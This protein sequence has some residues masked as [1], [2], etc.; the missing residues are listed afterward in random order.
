MS[1]G[2]VREQPSYCRICEPTCGVI[3]KVVG[4]R[5]VDVRPDPDNPHSQGFMCAKARA[6]VELVYDPDRVLHPLKRVGG[7]GE[8]ERV[9][10]DEALDDIARRLRSIIDRHGPGSFATFIGNPVTGNASG[11]IGY[12]G[13]RA[14]T[15]S[16][17]NYGINGEDAASFIAACTLQFGSPVLMPKP[18][19]W[20]T[21]FLLMAGANPTVSH[22]STISEPLVNHAIQG[23]VDRGGRVVV[24]DPRQT[25]TA[26]KFEHVPIRPGT[27]AWLFAGML[28]TI[29]D[30]DLYD[31]AFVERHTNDFESLA[32]LLRRFDIDRCSAASRVPSETITDLARAFARSPTAVAYGRTGTCTQRFGTLN[33][34]LI[35]TLNIVTGNLARRGGKV[36]GWGAIDTGKFARSSGMD[37]FGKTHT[38]VLGLPDAFGMLPSQSLWRDIS[39]PGPDQ[40]R[41][42]MF[43]STNPVLTSG[44][45][46]QLEQVIEQLELNFSLD[47]Y[48]TETNKYADYV[49]PAATFYERRDFPLATI[50]SMLRPSAFYTEKVIE[51]RGEARE[52]WRVFNDIA[53]RMGLG[54]A[55]SVAPLRWL[56][57]IGVVVDPHSLMDVMLRTGP[58]GDWFGLRRG[59][60]SLRKLRERHPHGVSIRDTT[61]ITPLEKSLATPDKRI[62]LA[63]RELGEEI[64]Q[65]LTRS[66]DEAFP[67]RIIGS[68]ELRSQ[69][70]WLHNSSRLVPHDRTPAALLNPDDAAAAGIAD[71]DEATI[72]SAQGTISM[73]VK[74]TSDVSPGTVVVPH[75]WGHAGGWQRANA[76]GGT[77]SNILTSVAPDDIER[78]AG[79]SILN[80]IPARISPTR[81]RQGAARHDVAKPASPSA[82]ESRPSAPAALH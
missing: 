81:Q 19:L 5:L 17:W 67:F 25:E 16:K 70:S 11:G 31:H 44:A 21:D 66:D 60:L 1:E 79:M 52:E 56:S 9:S 20:H 23:I 22:G 74:T 12:E 41:A 18:D 53:R 33:N 32:Q 64:E 10:W 58:A 61:P 78:I 43:Y 68:R 4:D 50:G 15:G 38:R 27:D 73:V 26:K 59:G 34:L 76:A 75:G 57:R 47:L 72:E 69:N 6:G 14:A 2:E 71:G 8:F 82:N 48:V 65:L 42:M 30:E 54:G 13:F 46:V 36:F 29:L 3:A 40:I 62:R 24:I 37:T 45:G 55:Y 80:G 49:L 39:E 63:P 35:N 28:R 51:P 77:N 7:P